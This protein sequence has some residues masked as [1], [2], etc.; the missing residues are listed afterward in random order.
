ML[1]RRSLGDY[2]PAD[3]LRDVLLVVTE[4][5]AQ[6]HER[7]CGE[8]DL[9]VVIIDTEI[10]G[11]LTGDRHEFTTVMT[12]DRRVRFRLMRRLL[13]RLDPTPNGDGVSF[14]MPATCPV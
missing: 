1:I 10:I 6:A 3:T 5:L 8:V 14:A 13:S 4:L 9:T 12:E 11:E 7:G 2:L